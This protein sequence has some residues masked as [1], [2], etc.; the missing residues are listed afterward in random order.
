MQTKF[1][2]NDS[3]IN[4]ISSIIKE[5]NGGEIFF[6]CILDENGNIFDVDPICYGNDNTV[7]AP[8]DI[9][10]KYNAILHNHPSSNLKPSEQ[11]LY[12]AE[13]LQQ[14][15]IGFF[16]T[17]NNANS[18]I[19]VVPPIISK[20]N[21]KIDF[22]II[23]SFFTEEN[24]I[25]KYITDYEFREGQQNMCLTVSKT[26]NENNIAIIEAGTGIGKTL[27][28]LIPAFYWA[29]INKERVIISTNTINLQNQ[30]LNKDIPI[31][32]KILNSDIKAV[33]VKGRRNYL[34]K[35]KVY[36]IQNELEFDEQAEE[37]NS[38]F[39]WT[40]TTENGDI[41]E[42]NFIPSFSVWERF[43]S[44]FDFCTGR[45]CNYFQTCFFQKARRKASESNILIVNHHILFADIDIKSKGRGIDE[46]IF[47]P[48]YKKIIFDE[49]HNIIKSAS[50]YFSYVFSKS[51]FY[52]FLGYLKKK[53]NK[54]F[55]P[56]FYR[57]LS[58]S[59]NNELEE[60]AQI[61]K[62]NVLIKFDSL[63]NNSIEIFDII[64]IYLDKIIK[65]YDY[66]FE[67]KINIQYRIKKNE[68]ESEY[69]KLNFIKNFN[70]LNDKLEELEKSFE[71]VIIKFDNIK[72]G[73]KENF[74]IDFKIFRSYQNKIIS[75]YQ[76]L[77]HL[78]DIDIEEYI[79]WLDIT[80]EENNP[81]FRFIATPLH[82]DKILVQNLYEVYNSIIL[83]SATL[84][85]NKSID[86]FKSLSGLSLVR[87]KEIISEIIKSPFNYKEK[88]IFIT[89]NDIPVPNHN[90][91]NEKINIFLKDLLKTI[92]GSSFVLFTSYVQLKK[93]FNEVN[94]F[95]NKNGLK[96]YFQGEMEKSK[97]LEKFILN[98][99]SSLFATNSFWEGVDA[100]GKTL[101]CVILA[102]LPFNIP[103]NPI[104]EAKIEDMEKRGINSFINYTLPQAIIK[105]RQGIGRLIRKND[106][107][108]VIG[109]LD[110]RILQKSY[111]KFFLN[112]IPECEIIS[113]NS[114]NILKQIEKHF[115]K[116]ELHIK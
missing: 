32:K 19:T 35:L 33:L 99:N 83:S 2:L 5:Y 60:V 51:S 8:Y 101:K 29:D 78:I 39:E 71:E 40:K 103:T 42:L 82:L 13:Y 84:T 54:G 23:N 9:V 6:G 45:N 18:L 72:K 102:K 62:N 112:S 98:I 65:N 11:D 21:K 63:M 47:L 89:P 104:E 109:I 15:G 105:F 115:K 56:R 110:S 77:I 113:S 64:N 76:D 111:G 59:N 87:E 57:R 22:E 86:Y 1:F 114:E 67:N 52:K 27:A 38:L 53:R 50:S 7:L 68:W 107:Y 30:L 20:K 25:V 92:N 88:V 81:N 94:D 44:D 36:N 91:Y 37:F 75:F 108:G 80:G 14:E 31:V 48:P 3:L 49:A 46:N 70:N 106:D 55:L 74:E 24:R 12:Y 16:I 4:K 96:C 43:S 34:C 10:N 95:L 41:D 73:V 61:I 66:L 100:P 79:P 58:N 116:F 28:Y 26:F 97:L 93:S 90:D 85:V 17:D 69:F